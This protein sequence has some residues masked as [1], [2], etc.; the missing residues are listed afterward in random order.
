MI[1]QVTP[2]YAPLP[3]GGAEGQL[4]KL[5]PRLAAK[6]LRV[7]VLTWDGGQRSL[8]EFEV[9]DGVPVH[10]LREAWLSFHGERR[11]PGVWMGITLL[12]FLLRRR[13]EVRF[14]HVHAFT[15]LAFFAKLWCG[16]LRI[17]CVAKATGLESIQVGVRGRRGLVGRAMWR[18][19]T[20][21]GWMIAMSP[22]VAN[23]LR[24][25][26]VSGSRILL[27]PNG[28]EIPP[29][30]PSR[31]RKPGEGLLIA[32]CSNLIRVKRLDLLIGAAAILGE[33]FRGLRWVV[34]G[35]GPERRRLEDL[36][37]ARGVAKIEW[38]GQVADVGALFRQADIFVHPSDFEG[39]SNSVLEAMA[40]GV[41]PVVRRADFHRDLVEDGETGLMFDG[42]E[43]DLA[44]RIRE[45]VLDERARVRLGQNAHVAAR[46]YSFE[47]VCEEYLRLLTRLGIYGRRPQ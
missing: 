39:M 11:L 36:C 12:G 20:R 22:T 18:F 2:R 1:L 15:E 16:L 25:S 29:G 10:R 6:G 17:P 45:L 27:L 30:I 43:A 14:V 33:E 42:T 26:G 28:V 5:A 4:R 9:L 40:Y 21:S 23:A 41:P 47:I 24:S 46:R 34:A 3:H 38:P 13:R 37:R 19:M 7:A 32:A 8:P 35:D 44:N 31:A